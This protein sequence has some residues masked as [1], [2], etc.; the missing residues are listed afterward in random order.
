MESTG[1]KDHSSSEQANANASSDKGGKK[2]RSTLRRIINWVI[3]STVF[4]LLLLYVL[5]A[6]LKWD[7]GARLEQKLK[8]LRERE[9][10]VTLD[11]V[12]RKHKT[13]LLALNN[14]GE[15]RLIAALDAMD[16]VTESQEW[17]VLPVVGNATIPDP[18]AE[19][20]Q[21]TMGVLK[22]FLE[23]YK[24]FFEL[25]ERAAA[26]ER[27]VFSRAYKDGFDLALPEVGRLR[28]AARISCLRSMYA[29][30]A[31]N[32][33]EVLQ[34]IGF[35]LKLGDA[36]RSDWLII[37]QLVRVAVYQMAIV[38][39]E[40]ALSSDALTAD[41]LARLQA[42]VPAEMDMEDL[43]MS[44]IG[45][46]AMGLA[47]FDSMAGGGFDLG[48]LGLAPPIAM[49]FLP[50]GWIKDQCI[51]Y[52]NFMTAMVEQIR[53]PPRQACAEIRAR[54]DRLAAE[55]FE[56]GLFRQSQNFI[57]AMLLPAMSSCYDSHL[58]ATQR[59]LL[60]RTAIAA[61]RFRRDNGRFPDTLDELVPAYLA[62]IP[63]DYF[64][65]GKVG[66]VKNVAGCVIYS[67]GLDGQDNKGAYN[68]NDPDGSGGNDMV[69]RLVE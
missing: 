53:L 37:C 16:A 36:L 2:P 40:Y 63:E 43:R 3:A 10:V 25:M 65:A 35:V 50:K 23:S 6:V 21:D 38:Q 4:L 42:M 58:K 11:D 54:N 49:S 69:F 26:S 29:S 9:D 55:E 30:C 61:A 47:L 64:S 12:Q 1:D 31:G 56:G 24:R 13:M 7:A 27:C 20:P 14:N 18:G 39:V 5:A 59:L 66:Y 15:T 46:R 48:G 41:Q 22:G 17:N 67:F 62:E 60:A 32:G 19:L 68:K 57:L 28:K 52:L 51:R 44:L 34:S 8:E 45:E 33:E